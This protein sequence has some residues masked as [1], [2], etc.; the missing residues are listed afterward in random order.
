MSIQS[1]ALS[2][3]TQPIMA[4]EIGGKWGTE[5]L[6]TRFPLPAHHNEKAQE[7]TPGAVYGI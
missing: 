4:S 7:T 6:N 2:F 1:A 5:Y 3:A